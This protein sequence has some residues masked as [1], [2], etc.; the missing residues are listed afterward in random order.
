MEAEEGAVHKERMTELSFERVIHLF[1]QPTN[2][3]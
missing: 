3:S 1:I 2:T